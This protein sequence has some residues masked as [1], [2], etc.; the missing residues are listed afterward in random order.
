MGGRFPVLVFHVMFC[1]AA[2]RGRVIQQQIYMM[3]AM[4]FRDIQ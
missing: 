2:I 1:R 4:T 3:T